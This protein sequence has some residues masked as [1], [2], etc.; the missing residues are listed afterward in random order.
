[1]KKYN[2]PKKCKV[3][4]TGGGP[5]RTFWFGPFWKVLETSCSFREKSVQTIDFQRGFQFVVFGFH[6]QNDSG[7]SQNRKYVLENF[8]YNQNRL[9]WIRGSRLFLRKIKVVSKQYC[10]ENIFANYTFSFIPLVKTHVL[11]TFFVFS[12]IFQSNIALN[13]NC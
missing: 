4:V 6:E 13:H 12:D 5:A 11:R 9:L 10:F 3:G 8:Q 2:T 1:M 7:P